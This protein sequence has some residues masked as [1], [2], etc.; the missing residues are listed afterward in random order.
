MALDT[1]ALSD[2][3][4]R[5]GANRAVGVP[6]A[7]DAEDDRAVVR[8]WIAARS[9]SPATAKQ[10]ER[11]AERFPLWCV[12]ERSKAL[13]DASVEDCRAYMAVGG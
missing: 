3:S 9:G 5:S 11:E 13:A 12:L 10:Y 4:G 7:I 6:A 2:L 8:A 1:A